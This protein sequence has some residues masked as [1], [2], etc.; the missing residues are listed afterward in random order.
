MCGGS[1]RRQVHVTLRVR[2]Q[3]SAPPAPG[4]TQTKPNLE[5]AVEVGPGKGDRDTG[6]VAQRC[7]SYHVGQG[8]V[9]ARLNHIEIPTRRMRRRRTFSVTNSSRG[10]GGEERAEGGN[11]DKK[12]WPGGPNRWSF[13]GLNS[14]IDQ[15][16]GKSVTTLFACRSVGAADQHTA[17]NPRNRCS[18]SFSS[19]KN[20]SRADVMRAWWQKRST[21]SRA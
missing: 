5:G 11:G 8:N 3:A 21:S 6:V 4:P 10:R 9:R 1:G 17:T 13:M 20:I 15:R 14:C 19:A 16:D 12:E 2:E 7:L 18:S